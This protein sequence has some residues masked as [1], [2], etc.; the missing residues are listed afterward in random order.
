MGV[1]IDSSSFIVW[2]EELIQE[3]SSDNGNLVPSCLMWIMWKERNNRTFE[4][5]ECTQEELHS[6]LIQMLFYWSRVWGFT[7][8]NS[9]LEFQ[10]LSF[11]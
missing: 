1:A 8:C 2:L 6:M 10:T 4:N 5:I 11:S 9:L 3:R 7:H